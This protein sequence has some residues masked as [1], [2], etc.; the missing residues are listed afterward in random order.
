MQGEQIYAFFGSH[1]G[2]VHTLQSYAVSVL[3]HT[4]APPPLPTPKQRALMQK[5]ADESAASFQ[6]TIYH[7]AGGV[8]AQYFHTA[9][10]SSA[11]ASMNLGSRPAKRKAAGGIE[12]L[13][14]IPWVFAWTQL[15]LHLPVWLGGGEALK[16]MADSPEGL[17][18]LRE[19]YK[20]WPFFSGLVDL[21]E[22]E[23]S[24]ANPKVSAYYDAKCC[25]SDSN[26]T[27]LG[28]ELREKLDEAVATFL[29]IAGKSELLEDQPLTKAAFSARAHYMNALHA[30][31]G[32]A[33]GR[34]RGADAPAEGTETYRCLNDAMI[35][36][37]QGI[38]A[39]MQNTG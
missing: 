8:F 28:K 13:R 30:L 7:S 11:L 6:Q 29:K 4:V 34:M 16:K 18:E 17:E 1:G 5:L 19:M 27:A 10:P 14:A 38:A 2:A 20:S 36:T 26:L 37:V 33:M 23:I 25:S 22:L 39:G 21:V 9:S 12:T 35:V 31:Q 32:E 24:K 15:R 3:E